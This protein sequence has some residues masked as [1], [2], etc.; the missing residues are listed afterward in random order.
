MMLLRWYKMNDKE[1]RISQ[2]EYMNNPIEE[3]YQEVKK[4]GYTMES[5]TKKDKQPS[6]YTKY[7]FSPVDAFQRGLISKDEYVGFLKG[8]IIKYIVRAGKKGSTVEDLLKA[9]S[10]I[11]YYLDMESSEEKLLEREQEHIFE[12]LSKDTILDDVDDICNVDDIDDDADVKKNK[13]RLVK[14]STAFMAED[15]KEELDG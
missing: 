12:I 10:Y 5:L 13:N 15:K 9:K 1:T 7:G 3:K 2:D 8:N 6:Y 4:E 14:A 11:N